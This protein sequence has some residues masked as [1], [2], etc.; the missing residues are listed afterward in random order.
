[1]SKVG[2]FL[3]RM[4]EVR[5][6]SDPQVLLYTLLRGTKSLVSPETNCL[7]YSTLRKSL[8]TKQIYRYKIW[9]KC[10]LKGFSYLSEVGAFWIW[11]NIIWTIKIGKSRFGLK[12]L[13]LHFEL[14][15]L[16]P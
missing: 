8:V 2:Q 5:L 14:S 6:F 15:D 13:D 3:L 4:H 9:K 7:V 1:M 10:L 12:E 11:E 16:K